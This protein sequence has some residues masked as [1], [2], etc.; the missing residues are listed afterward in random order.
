M[1]FVTDAEAGFL[2]LP[3]LLAKDGQ[4]NSLSQ[5]WESRAGSCGR[6]RRGEPLGLGTPSGGCLPHHPH[7]NAD[8]NKGKCLSV[9]VF[10]LGNWFTFLNAHSK[11]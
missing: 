7:L 5:P 3:C 6:K 9:I 4:T 8:P 1:D 2:L 11:M 10:E